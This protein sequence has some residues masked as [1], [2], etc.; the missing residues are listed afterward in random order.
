M[1]GAV[2][3]HGTALVHAA[4]CRTQADSVARCHQSILSANRLASPPSTNFS[5]TALL[6]IADSTNRAEQYWAC[7][8]FFLVKQGRTPNRP[9]EYMVDIPCIGASSSPCHAE[10]IAERL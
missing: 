10:T 2:Y 7:P 4:R 3:P 6:Q 9:V 8:L 1:A 5:T